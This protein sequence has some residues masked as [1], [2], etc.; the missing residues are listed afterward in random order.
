MKKLVTILLVLFVFV[1]W[2]LADEEIISNL[3]LIQRVVSYFCLFHYE[4][5]NLKATNLSL[6]KMLI[7]TSCIQ[8]QTC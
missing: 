2:L 5:K 8:A 3:K 6:P 4:K 1:G 7:A